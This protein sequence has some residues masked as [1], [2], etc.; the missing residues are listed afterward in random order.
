MKNKFITFCN[1][2]QANWLALVIFLTVLWCV[3]L[4]VVAGSWLV[5]FWLNGLFGYKFELGSCW[6]GVGAIAAA[7]AGII[8]LAKAGWTKWLIDSEHNS[9]QYVPP[10]SDPK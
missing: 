4:L 9:P 8:G 3:M 7:F 1:W 5:A 10:G 6:Q 2:A